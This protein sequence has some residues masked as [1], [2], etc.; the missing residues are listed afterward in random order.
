MITLNKRTNRK[1]TYLFL[2]VPVKEGLK[3]VADYNHTTIS[4]LLEEGAKKVIHEET[5]KM[6]EDMYNLNHIKSIVSH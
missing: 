6:R 5:L 4:Y 2:S 3:K 1:P